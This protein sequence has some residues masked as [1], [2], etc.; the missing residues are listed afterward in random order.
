MG[1]VTEDLFLYSSTDIEVR[2]SGF[3]LTEFCLGLIQ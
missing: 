1:I 2:S 3:M